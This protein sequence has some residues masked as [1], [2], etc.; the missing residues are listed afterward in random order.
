MIAALAT[1]RGIVTAILLVVLAALPL[2]TQA[3]DQRYLLSV[4]T[5][6]VI[7]S[8][9]AVSLNMIL[10][11]GGLVSFGH[12]AFFGIGGYA[13]GILS[14]DGIQDGWL[15]WPVA[16]VACVLWA[17]LIGALSL[18]TRGVY[19]IMITLA[20]AQLVYY[21]SSG[22]E[23]YGGDD[24]LNISRSRF[25]L[26][27]LRDKTSFYWLCF[28]LLLATLWF[29]GRMAHSRFGYVLRGARSNELRMM[30][31]GFPVF[32]YRLAAFTISGALGGLSGI[33]L[34]NDGAYVSPAMMSWVK[35][36]DLIV[37]VVLGGIGC[38]SARSTAPS[39][40]SRSR[41]C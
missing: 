15:Q 22:L 1:P 18:R 19:F 34:A 16:I 7:W 28:V 40:S 3:F 25:W 11:Y 32:R 29:C 26:I 23:A 39:S 33:L 31:L 12:A 17:A 8:I 27:D 21:L 36:G 13:V 10:G 24:G 4:G 5:R 41:R 37:I 9:A 38:A 20:F 30:A 6:I 35:S 14:A 2:L